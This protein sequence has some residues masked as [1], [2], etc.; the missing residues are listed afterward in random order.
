M[1]KSNDC[2]CTR[3]GLGVEGQTRL[4]CSTK[5]FLD[6][7]NR[8]EKHIRENILKINEHVPFVQLIEKAS[9]L[10]R[11]VNQYQTALREFGRF[12]NFVV[13]ESRSRNALAIPSPSSIE[14]IG[15]LQDRLL[16]PPKLVVV[17]RRKVETCEASE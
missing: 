4:R 12:H 9:R 15:M 17:C 16:S 2:P 7:F 3:L 8:I 13:H 11:L 14:R 10:S 6:A 1:K 5:Q